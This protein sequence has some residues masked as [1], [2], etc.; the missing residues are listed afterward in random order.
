[1]GC[2]KSRNRQTHRTVATLSS[3]KTDPHVPT[4]GMCRPIISGWQQS[5]RLRQ[6]H[7]ASWSEHSFTIQNDLNIIRKFCEVWW[8]ED[9]GVLELPGCDFPA[10]EL[11]R[12]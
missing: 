10:R 7:V 5:S 11:L 8:C 1:M 3:V 4:N 6:A 12:S 9:V 2:V